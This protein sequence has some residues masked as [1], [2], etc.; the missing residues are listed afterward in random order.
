[1]D[2]PNFEK[3]GFLVQDESLRVASSEFVNWLREEG[4]RS[5]YLKGCYGCSWVFV[6]ITCKTFAYGMPGIKIVQPVGN[7]AVTIDEFRT[8][9]GIYKKYD[10][11]EPL[12]F[13][14][15]N[16]ARKGESK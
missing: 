4:F 6:S 13:E 15:A 11:L 9:Y 16:D 5:A 14:S 7:H 1:M 8:I 2:T 10:G 12:V 3:V